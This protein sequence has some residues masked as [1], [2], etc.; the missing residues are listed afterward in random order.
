MTERRR[1]GRGLGAL[2]PETIDSG[3]TLREINISQIKA[4]PNQPRTRFDQEKLNELADSIREHG[5]VQ[6][7]IVSPGKEGYVLVAGERRFRAAQIAGL[8]TIPALTKELDSGTMLQIALIEN[9]QR[10]DLNPVEQARAY[11]QLI[12]KFKFTQEELAR[13]L[14]KSRPAIANTIRLLSL[15][16]NIKQS[17]IN[18]ELS[19]G[20]ARPL[21]RMPDPEAQAGLARRIVQ[22][23]LSAREV[24]RL[25]SASRQTSRRSP[26]KTKP[27]RREYTQEPFWE[28][29]R[30][31][32][33]HY[34][35]TKV[36]ISL[37][38]KGGAIEI[39]FYDPEDLERLL[40]LIMP[41]D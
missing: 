12:D 7:I 40:A 15:P 36:K 17:L 2:I 31:K 24:E 21:L 3:A 30:E 22:E 32:L 23:K 20:Q 29:L 19:E 41:G 6:P 28:E 10:E 5:V 34:L 39:E 14:G 8:Q 35:G 38:S 1:L 26:P 9:L 11:Q 13:R 18:G 37:R 4:N 27:L 25:V 33:Q 16:D